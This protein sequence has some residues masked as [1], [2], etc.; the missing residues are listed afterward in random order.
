MQPSKAYRVLVV[1]DEGLIAHDIARRLETLGH[2]VVGTVATAD[3]AVALAPQADLVLMDIRIDGKRD[4]VDA[5]G[6]I[7][8]RCHVPVV[9]LTAHAD[10][11]TLERAKLA[12]PSGY[13]VKP[14][15]PATLQSSIEI[16]IYKHSAERQLEEREAW[17][18]TT[19]ASAAEG[20]VA[21]DANGRVLLVNRAAEALTGWTQ[22]EAQGQSIGTVLKLTQ[23]E[24]DAP[25]H[26]WETLAILKDAPVTLDRGVHIHS[27]SG[28]SI[29]VAGSAAPVRV[30]AGT[31]GVV[32]TLHDITSQQWHDLQ[33][34]QSQRAAAI[35]RLAAGIAG[36]YS[37]LLG[38]IRNQAVQLAA[39]FGEFM[40][41]RKALDQIEQTIAK[42]EQVTHYLAG[43]GDRRPGDPEVTS[44]NGILRRMAGTIES[45]ADSGLTIAIEPQGGAGRIL[46]DPTQLEQAIM[47]LVLRAVAMSSTGGAVSIKTSRVNVPTAGIA[48]GRG[49]SVS[50]SFAVLTLTYPAVEPE[51]DRLFDPSGGGENRF[52]LVVAQSI[53]T[54]QGGVIAA[55]TSEKGTEIQM[56]FPVVEETPPDG[57]SSGPIRTILLIE[58]RGLVRAHLHNVAESAGYNL[59]EATDAADAIGL[60]ELQDTPVDLLIATPEDALRTTSGLSPAQTPRMV[61]RLVNR[62]E[63]GAGELQQPFTQKALLDRIAALGEA[64]LKPGGAQAAAT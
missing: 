60:C 62:A 13:V 52:G 53:V 12:G 14:L 32:V 30:S 25:V 7:R 48:P 50:A 33:V 45:A 24:S 8:A 19:V 11:S 21:A 18:R 28:V 20:I 6:E 55:K 36:Q 22:A 16:A 9:F 34:R 31:I 26:D 59:L 58:P 63:R 64:M 40:P 56:Q 42:A 35:A 5:A 4:G 29:E 41:A 57:L 38:L 61:L 2:T 17:L 27:R 46:A 37:N 23:G 43:L 39:Q 15:G 54:D 47:S 10:R 1:E 51:V 49:H 44:L 3:E